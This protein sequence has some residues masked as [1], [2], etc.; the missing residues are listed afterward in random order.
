MNIQS[1]TASQSQYVQICASGCGNYPSSSLF[2]YNHIQRPGLLFAN[3]GSGCGS[4]NYVYVAFSMMDGTAWPYPNG[5]VFGYN[6]AN[7]SGGTEFYY[8]TSMGNHSTSSY[9][10]GV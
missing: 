2:S 7:L 1:L 8:Q 5:T 4:L 6:A 10:G 3:C 9:G